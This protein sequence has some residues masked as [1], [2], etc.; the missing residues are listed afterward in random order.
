MQAVTSEASVYGNP[1]VTWGCRARYFCAASVTG[2]ASL[3]NAGAITRRC[4]GYAVV[5]Y[6]VHDRFQ[7][8]F[9]HVERLG[10]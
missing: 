3:L 2:G 7:F 6:R 4:H 5:G 9:V 8:D 10:V 1:N